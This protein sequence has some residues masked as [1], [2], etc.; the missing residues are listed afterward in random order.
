MEENGEIARKCKQANQ[1]RDRK[2]GKN[3]GIEEKPLN[4]I[5]LQISKCVCVCIFS[6]AYLSNYIT[7]LYIFV[8]LYV[9]IVSWEACIYDK[10][11]GNQNVLTLAAGGV[12]GSSHM[13]SR[14]QLQYLA[15]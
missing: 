2:K 12:V 10:C 14:N 5:D 13:Q 9:K 7:K 8:K 15:L 4:K 3:N 6:L 11:A 1:R